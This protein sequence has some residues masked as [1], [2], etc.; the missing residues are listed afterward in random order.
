MQRLHL[1]KREL[2]RWDHITQRMTVPF[3]PEYPGII[4]QF[5]GW[6]KLKE[7]DW[8]AY[9]KRYGKI[10]RLDRILKAEGDSPD[11]YQVCKQADTCMLFYL[12]TE[13]ELIQ[14]MTK[15]GYRFSKELIQ[16]NITYYIK[17]TS[18]GSTLSYVVFSQIIHKMAPKK[19]WNLYRDFIMSDIAD[20]QGGTTSEGIHTVPLASTVNMILLQYCGIDTSRN[21]VQINPHLIKIVE[22]LSF[23]FVYQHQW[24]HVQLKENALTLSVDGDEG[25]AEKVPVIIN[26]TL[27]FLMPCS[28]MQFALS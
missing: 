20:T 3:L 11:R 7:L 13:D 4:A 12:L 27:H 21:A 15:L 8:Q 28:S 6:D 26:D 18:H 19:A 24:I 25:R 10:N 5:E 14:V 9:R 1:T 23:R 17:R 22:R 2:D 16:K